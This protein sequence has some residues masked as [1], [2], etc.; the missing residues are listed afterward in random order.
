[1]KKLNKKG[2]TLVELVIVVA[3]IAI[4]SAVLIP[5]VSGLI[6]SSKE[7]ALKSEA[8]NAYTQY[9]SEMAEKNEEAAVNMIYT[10]NGDDKRYI[11]IKDGQLV[12]EIKMFASTINVYNA[13]PT[14]GNGDPTGPSPLENDMEY[15]IAEGGSYKLYGA[16]NPESVEGIAGLYEIVYTAPANP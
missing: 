4:L 10:K 16:G 14:D 5:T 15:D 6:S 8:R 12:D 13:R 9:V 1:M 11:L 3:V 7:A 2:F